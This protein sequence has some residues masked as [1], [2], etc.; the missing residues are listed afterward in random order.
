MSIGGIIINID[1]FLF[2]RKNVTIANNKYVCKAENLVKEYKC[3]TEDEKGDKWFSRK[4]SAT[5]NTIIKNPVVN[6]RIQ[7]FKIHNDTNEEIHREFLSFMNKLSDK[8]KNST[9]NFI[10]SHCKQAY[11]DKYIEIIW[12]MML[13]SP[14]YQ[15]N[16]IEILKEISN[17]SNITLISSIKLMWIL[18][19]TNKKWIP[20]EELLNED[21]YD[22]FCD[23]LKWKKR[24]LASI[25]AYSLFIKEGW[26]DEDVFITLL[27]NIITDGKYYIRLN[28]RLKSDDKMLDI[29]LDHIQVLFDI[30]NNGKT[31]SSKKSYKIIEDFISDAIYDIENLKTTSRFKIMDMYDKISRKLKL[32]SISKKDGG[33]QK[34]D[35][36]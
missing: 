29:I 25:K 8:N 13:R 4:P 28:N 26:I 36:R 12:D 16:Y 27:Q 2:V 21:D 34:K 9:I 5:Y 7:K 23:F 35:N 22:E 30:I 20:S 18:F 17:I 24:S 1:Q 19:L 33:L 32:F 6:S 14:D 15:S 3:F 11:I 10:R 31:D